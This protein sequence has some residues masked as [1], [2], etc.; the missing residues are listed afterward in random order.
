MRYQI[1]E[2]GLKQYGELQQNTASAQE[3]T[4]AGPEAFPPVEVWEP[5]LRK[6]VVEHPRLAISLSLLAG[7]LLGCWVKR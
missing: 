7:V 3:Q 4:Q 2:N 5:H 1:L 6:Q